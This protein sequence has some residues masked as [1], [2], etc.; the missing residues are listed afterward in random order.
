MTSIPIRRLGIGIALVLLAVSTVEGGVIV[1]RFLPSS[2][3]EIS[4]LRPG[5]AITSW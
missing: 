1:E 2:S 5:D 3:A 4:G